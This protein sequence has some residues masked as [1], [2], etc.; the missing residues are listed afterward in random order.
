MREKDEMRRLMM[1]QNKSRYFTNFAI[2][3]F[4]IRR[5]ENIMKEEIEQV[6][7]QYVFCL[8]CSLQGKFILPEPD[9]TR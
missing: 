8:F 7:H 9:Q 4:M 2:P 6:F 5:K 1:E 3:G